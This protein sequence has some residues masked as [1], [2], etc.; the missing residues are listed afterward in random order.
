MALG[1]TFA[2][3]MQGAE[4]FWDKLIVS[5]Y[6]YKLQL[7]E[8][9]RDRL[10]IVGYAGK[11]DKTHAEQAAV[12]G[13]YAT[14]FQD[15]DGR[16]VKVTTDPSDMFAHWV[17]A[18]RKRTVPIHAQY[19]IRNRDPSTA[20]Q[21]PFYYVIITDFIPN[22]PD[23]PMRYVSEQPVD[24]YTLD[25]RRIL[26]AAAYPFEPPS[27]VAGDP[28]FTFNHIEEELKSACKPDLLVYLPKYVK[29]TAEQ[30]K[31]VS[32]LRRASVAYC[33]KAGREIAELATYLARRGVLLRDLHEHN[34][35]MKKDGEWFIR[36]MGASVGKDTPVPEL[37]GLFYS[38][39]KGLP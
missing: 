15:I 2:G 8:T 31:Y 20:A 13:G 17:A 37:Q 11:A 33:K 19:S 18:G 36:D 21:H 38:S 6:G 26:P 16:V 10:R 29:L 24:I 3:L 32:V 5:L 30:E 25:Y 12:S 23:A 28:N 39:F 35:G 4:P 22:L 27:N 1:Y 7:T 9:Q 14:A 34:F